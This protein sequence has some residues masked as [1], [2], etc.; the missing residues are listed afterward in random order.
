MVSTG[1]PSLEDNLMSPEDI[2]SLELLTVRWSEM[3]LSP[4]FYLE[5]KTRTV[6]N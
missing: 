4:L 1:I 2:K 3:L 5:K 6:T